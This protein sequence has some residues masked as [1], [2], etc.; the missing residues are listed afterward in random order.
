M[1]LILASG[2]PYRKS[3]LGRLGLPFETVVPR[4]DESPLPNERFEDTARRLSIEKARAVAQQHP[5]A[6]VIGSDQVAHCDGQR[7][8]KPGT[9]EAAIAQLKWQRG[10]TSL[11]HTALCVACNGGDTLQTD[12]ITTEVHFWDER[13]LTDATLEHYVALEKPL[14]CAGAAKSEG[15]GISLMAAMRGDDPTALVGLPLIALCR[16]LRDCG[17]DPLASKNSNAA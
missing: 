12:L 13:V 1:R 7:L 8:D 10:K 3:L 4:I 14:D 17:L 9:V 5:A 2:S 15:L 11:F 16:L 6:I